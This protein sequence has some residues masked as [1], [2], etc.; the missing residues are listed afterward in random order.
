MA[1]FVKRKFWH[2]EISQAQ[3]TE[4]AEVLRLQKRNTG[5]S[6]SAISNP[7]WFDRCSPL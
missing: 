4:L 6:H 3:A 5:V 7:K 1:G 2:E